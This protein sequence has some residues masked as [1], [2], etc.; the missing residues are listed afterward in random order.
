[1]IPKFEG[2]IIFDIDGT[3]ANIQHR[4]HF[5]K[6]KPKNWNKFNRGLA[7]DSPYED[8]IWLLKLMQSAGKRI[9]ICSGRSEYQRAATEKWLAEV[10]NVTYEKLYMRASDDYRDDSIVKKEL[11]DQ[12][13]SEGYDPVMAIDDRDRVVNMWREQGIRCLQVAPGNF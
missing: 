10:A 11:L 8:I 5:L 7:E 2:D 1:M 4:I 6:T 9:V 3:L 13:R 12:M